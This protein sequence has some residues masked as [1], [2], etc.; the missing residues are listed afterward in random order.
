MNGIES[1]TWHSWIWRKGVIVL[2]RKV[3]RMYGVNSKLNE[4]GKLTVVCYRDWYVRRSLMV[5]KSSESDC[6]GKKS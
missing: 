6:I 1:C 4:S 3:L 5:F 2:R